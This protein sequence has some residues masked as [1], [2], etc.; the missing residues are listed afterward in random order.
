M[1]IKKYYCKTL[2]DYLI[3]IKREDFFSISQ[4]LL[5]QF[6]FRKFL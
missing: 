2:M 4:Y 1:H 3:K 5:T 6:A